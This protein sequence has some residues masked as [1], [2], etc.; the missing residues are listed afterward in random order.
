MTTVFISVSGPLS[1]CIGI[2]IRNALSTYFSSINTWIAIKDIDKGKSWRTVLIEG[3][4]KQSAGIVVLTAR[5][6]SSPWILYEA[7]AIAAMSGHDRVWTVLVDLKASDITGPLAISQ[8][9]LLQEHE[10]TSLASVIE[11]YT[12]RP[13]D[14]DDLKRV[15]ELFAKEIMTKAKECLT[16]PQN[17]EEG[18]STIPPRDK[19]EVLGDVLEVVRDIQRQQSEMASR[20]PVQYPLSGI[21]GLTGATGPTGV[22]FGPQGT[23]VYPSGKPVTFATAGGSTRATVITRLQSED[24]LSGSTPATQPPQ[25]NG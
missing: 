23:M 20:L 6:Q 7:G 5:N 18:T 19:D 21:Q 22:A 9:T 8:H 14:G 12:D 11:K 1:T 16:N 24:P 4:T 15:S 17:K 13:R 2:A 3:L 10:L 25:S